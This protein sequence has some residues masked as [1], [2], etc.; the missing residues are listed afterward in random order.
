MNIANMDHHSS[1]EFVTEQAKIRSLRFPGEFANRPSQNN[2]VALVLVDVCKQVTVQLKNHDASKFLVI[3]FLSLK[4]CSLKASGNGSKIVSQY[5]ASNDASVALVVHGWEVF[6]ELDVFATFNGRLDIGW[7]GA[8]D[9]TPVA[10]SV[11]ASCT[12][13]LPV[14]SNSSDSLGCSAPSGT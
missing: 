12:K 7:G 13:S 4:T 2:Y 9:W 1:E 6:T 10:R 14:S 3:L 8:S 11:P 5:W